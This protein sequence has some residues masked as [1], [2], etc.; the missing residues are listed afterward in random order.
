MQTILGPFQPHLED[1]LVEEVLKYK[2]DDALRPLLIL[3]PSDALRRRLKI[4]LA[5][6]RN[7]SLI[8]LRL[9]T[10]YQLSS[11]LRAESSGL[12]APVL[13]DDLFLEE[14]LRRIIH[15]R[16]PGTEAFAG[17]E[18][19]SGG[20]AALWQS[21]RDLRDGMVQP[22]V[23]LEALR[24]G[25]FDARTKERTANLLSLLRTLLS[26]CEEH[27]I[28]DH[29]T[30]DKCAIARAPSADFLSRFARI[31]YYGFYDLTQIQLELFNAVARNYPT[32]L[33]FPLLQTQP[34]HEG[35]SFAEH[36]YQ[37]FIQGRG[38]AEVTTNLVG[39]S[40]R[41]IDLPLAFRIFDQ[42]LK[43]QY[44]PL[45]ANWQCRIF[46][47][48]G[49]HDEV[50]TVAKEILRLVG[51][52]RIAF[53]EIAVVARSLDG[54]GATL[55]EIFGLHQI[56]ITGA[57]EEPLVQFPLTK[58]AMLLQNLPAKDYLRSHVIDLLSSP[59][60]QF[61]PHANEGNE[62]RP[63]LWDLAT[64][65]LAICKGMNEWQ[66]L[67]RYAIDGM[68]LAQV[69]D[70]DERRYIEIPAA[71]LRVLARTLNGLSKEL[72]RLP[73]RGSWSQYAAS[74]KQLFAKHLGIM[75]DLPADPNA[76]QTLVSNKIIE[77]LDQMAGLDALASAIS[78]R[79]FSETFQ[80]WLE[81]ST[82]VTVYKNIR[83][84]TVSNATSARG[85]NFRAL[86]IVAMN[87]G[88]F[89][90]TIREDAFLRDADRRV[91]ECV[92][93]YKV[94][95][96][97]ASFDEEKLLFTLLVNSARERLYCS[98]QRSDEGGRVL[99]PSWYLADL[100]RALTGADKSQ[101]SEESIP[102][103][104]TDKLDF[105]PF[106]SEDLL[107]PDELAIGLSL[108]GKSSTSLI[109][110]AGLSPRLYKE[111]V[112]TIE[113]IDLS[114]ERL[115]SFDGMLARIDEHWRRFSQQGLSPTRLEL[116]ARCP[117]QY[118][119]RQMLG[120]ERLERPEDA[121][122]PST[123]EFGELGHLI[124]K[125]TYQDLI[126]RGYFE[127]KASNVALDEV[128]DRAAQKAFTDYEAKNPIGYPLMWDT[129]RETLTESIRAALSYDLKELAES[130]FTP[131]AFE[132]DIAARLPADWP[133]PLGGLAIHGRVDRIDIDP[134][135]NRIR[136]VDYKFKF[137]GKPAAE[138]NNLLRSALRGQRL[139]PPFYSVLG[140]V[141]NERDNPSG[142]Q[143]QVEASFYFIA[144]RWSQGPLSTQS[145]NVAELSGRIGD[146]IKQTIA[147]LAKG[148]Q[149]G[150]FFMQRG[151]HCPRC[152]VAEI[153]RKNHPP[154]LWRTENDPI[155]APH[156]Q[157][158]EKDPNQL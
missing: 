33:L 32:T 124:L 119:A 3:T 88:V 16:Q 39:A 91:L 126:Q 140:K 109:E 158:R 121:M 12:Q 114:S 58:A 89:P 81:R 106:D 94:G 144:P 17:I 49:I 117:F 34:A 135:H 68:K 146:E 61:T 63:D 122:G 43:R 99:A 133:E 95:E 118:F 44:Q 28:E 29:S 9:M 57:I 31:F 59:C 131:A 143:A 19:R 111:G 25:H 157:L 56:P 50:S 6:E 128:V 142:T 30:Q 82:I 53:D 15:S 4:L 2:Q 93:G 130:G 48:F 110:A 80:H 51:G 83:G 54:Y 40:D 10:F 97:Y 74:W 23:G 27:R 37:S 13:R 46:S 87:E 145:F 45:P 21:L 134:G 120:L 5:R 112:K 152:E 66:R 73:E 154:S 77:I 47:T 86:F 100:K 41:Q 71:S 70:D 96:K 79:D 90:R 92:L 108:A 123:G 141:T 105:S 151:E 64:R 103:S 55:K 102:R 35:W 116:Y 129:V 138:D 107:L 101:F 38:S 132:T 113:R 60:F 139:Q 1:S 11:Q 14:T 24:E 18:Q 8:N 65:E 52:G 153:C 22:E 115:A 98:F 155:T 148:I 104:T 7:L 75:T 69:S 72:N 62:L 127:A 147:Q 156:R 84:V 125:L 137:G 36:F 85:L 136:V 76:T 149:S 150:R 67:E 78:L 26:F 20:C 42:D